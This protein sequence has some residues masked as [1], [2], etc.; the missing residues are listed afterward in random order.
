MAWLS[1]AFRSAPSPIRTAW[2]GRWRRATSRDEASLAAGSATCCEH[3]AGC[4]TTLILLGR[5]PS[6]PRGRRRRRRSPSQRPRPGPGASREL[7]LET[8]AAGPQ[9]PRRDARR[10][11]P[12]RTSTA[13]A[14]ALP[15]RGR[16]S[17]RRRR[18]GRRPRH[19]AGRALL[20][21]YGLAFVQ[22]LVSAALRLG[23]DR[24]DRRARGHRRPDARAS[25]RSREQ[26]AGLQPRRPR[27]ARLRSDLALVAARD[28]VFEALPHPDERRMASPTAPCASAS[29]APSAPARPR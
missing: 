1:P 20:A 19:A 24:A 11:G 13:L 12:C 9:L 27:L 16:L 7:H 17:G 18:C 4:A 2:N 5:T 28:P 29:A 3:G 22:N 25:P 6:A 10:H 8:S 21:A 26:A 23:A 14:E 15:G